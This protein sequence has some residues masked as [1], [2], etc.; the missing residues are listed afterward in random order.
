[1]DIKTFRKLIDSGDVTNEQCKE[2]ANVASDAIDA[3]NAFQAQNELASQKLGYYLL[4]NGI[5][6]FKIDENGNFDFGDHDIYS[7]IDKM[8]SFSKE[9]SYTN[10]VVGDKIVNPFPF[11]IEPPF[12]FKIENTNIYHAPDIK[13]QY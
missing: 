11:K 7:L 2:F 5:F 8:I 4:A 9:I 13:I 10:H 1:M 3:C 12:P 6:A